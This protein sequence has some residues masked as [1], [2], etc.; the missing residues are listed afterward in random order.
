MENR[1]NVD[2]RKAYSFF[3]ALFFAIYLAILPIEQFVD[4]NN[5]IN[6]ATY[7]LEI[8]GSR[9]IQGI[10]TLITNEPIWGIVNL[11]L[12]TALGAETC[13]RVIIAFSTF[14]TFYLVINNTKPK[15]FFLALLILLL[16]Q[17]L[18]NNI[19]HLR[20]GLAI[21]LFL[22]GW[23]SVKTNTRGMWFILAALT[24]SSFIIVIAGLVLVRVVQKLRFAND[25]RGLIYII[26]GLIV[27]FFGLVVAGFL[28][29]RQAEQYEGASIGASGMGFIFWLGVLLIYCLQGSKF[30]KS[31]SSSIF[32]LILYLTTYFFLPVT[33]RVF[34]S[35][36]II[37]L[38]SAYSLKKFNQI[39]FW[40]AYLFYFLFTWSL[41]VFKPGFG[42]DVVN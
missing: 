37:V 31:H 12:S 41:R 15:Y 30:L 10:S 2:L 36:L 42:W 24:H 1:Y 4:R 20:Q 18:K 26:S 11:V 32:F 27:G 6:F 39:Y 9:A 14:S 3:I 17:V 28:G 13:L 33:G 25:L 34:E 5:Y 7:T 23:F 22:W 29:A 35:V 8:L 21:S 19:I 38:M 40:M 16:P